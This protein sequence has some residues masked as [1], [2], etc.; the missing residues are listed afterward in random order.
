[1]GWGTWAYCGSFL[2]LV[3]VLA[4][5]IKHAPTPLSAIGV[6]VFIALISWL[7]RY[8]NWIAE[9]AFDHLLRGLGPKRAASPTLESMS[10]QVRHIFCA[11]ELH[12]GQHAFFS[13]DFVYAR[14][15]GLGRAKGLPV[16]TAVQVSANFPVGFPIRPLSVDRFDFCLTDRFEEAT[17]Y[18]FGMGRD[19]LMSDKEMASLTAFPAK[20]PPTPRHLMLTD[21]GVFDNL[22]VD[23]FLGSDV[24]TQRFKAPLNR[25][26][27]IAVGKWDDA[28]NAKETLVECLSVSWDC[29][30]VINAGITSRWA[31]GLEASALA[32]IAGELIGA[33]QITSTM[34]NNSTRKRLAELQHC[35][36][37]ELGYGERL[38]A[39]TLL[40]LGTATTGQLLS[41]G[42]SGARRA[43]ERKYA[44]HDEWVTEEV[45]GA[46]LRRPT[47]PISVATIE[48]AMSEDRSLGERLSR[49]ARGQ[50][51]PHER[52][53]ANRP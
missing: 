23:W 14:G 1:V 19:I 48:A 50:A 11:T 28:R 4:V 20:A 29:L 5:A 22:A 37:V 31:H 7:M 3:A 21:G 10:T 6:F 2:F 45:G 49:L 35:V 16:A 34:Y 39:T 33:F 32:P 44:Q 13:H 18:G 27:D 42:Y 41:A 38:V 43:L 46:V 24:R 25:D 17:E 30:I 36:L 40:P 12:S 51:T 53:A 8:R 9:R 52:A 15:F 26:Y 47:K